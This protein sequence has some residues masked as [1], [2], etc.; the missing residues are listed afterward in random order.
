MTLNQIELLTAYTGLLILV[1]DDKDHYVKYVSDLMDQEITEDDLHI[2]AGK[3]S[4]TAE[5]IFN[6][7]YDS[8]NKEELAIIQYYTG[9]SVLK[10]K[11]MYYLSAVSNYT[12]AEIKIKFYQLCLPKSIRTNKVQDNKV[13]KSIKQQLLKVSEIILSVLIFAALI[14]LLITTVLLIINIM[15]NKDSEYLGVILTDMGILF[16]LTIVYSIITPSNSK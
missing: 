3:V 1:R 13:K 16:V 5:P 15:K 12:D 8:Y 2:L 7:K 14:V 11:D 9:V 10:E 6:Q 4:E